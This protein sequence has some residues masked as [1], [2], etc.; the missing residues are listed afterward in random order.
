MRIGSTSRSGCH[1]RTNPRA[2]STGEARNGS[3]APWP[4]RQAGRSGRD[5]YRPAVSQFARAGIRLANTGQR[6]SQRIILSGEPPN[7]ADCP[8]GCAFQPH[9]PIAISASRNKHDIFGPYPIRMVV[10]LRACAPL[11]TCGRHL[12]LRLT[13]GCCALL[14]QSFAFVVLRQSGDP[15]L[16]I[17]GSETSADA[18]REFRRAWRLDQPLV[19]QYPDCLRAILHGH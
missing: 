2:A 11:R 17:M 7:P 15:S 10:R 19:E 8:G 12:M 16:Q 1:S 6:R 13:F 18:V 5:I 14:Q 9:S 3:D 4:C